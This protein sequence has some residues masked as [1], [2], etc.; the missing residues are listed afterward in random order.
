MTDLEFKL[1][2][3]E[4]TMRLCKLFAKDDFKKSKEY[5]GVN[6]ELKEYFEGTAKAF[7]MVAKFLEEDLK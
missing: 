2:R 1:K 7:E 6:Q 4:T 3:V 5:D